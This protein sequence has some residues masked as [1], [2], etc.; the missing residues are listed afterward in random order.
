MT[1][2]GQALAVLAFSMLAFTVIA[3]SQRAYAYSPTADFLDVFEY[4]VEL[5]ADE[6][7][8]E[9]TRAELAKNK[10]RDVF[11]DK[12]ERKITGFSVSATDVKIHMEPSRMDADRTRID[13]D[14]EGKNV[15]VESSYF[16]KKF[17]RLDVDT[18]YGVYNAKTDKVTV[19]IPFATAFSLAFR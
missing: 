12:I 8:T 15:A 18:I 19:H 3:G 6:I 13:I 2:G 5:D 10:P 16:N 1:P 7:M 4:K 11:I 9:Q 17:S 14:V